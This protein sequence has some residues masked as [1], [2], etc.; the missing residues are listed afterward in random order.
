[1]NRE[2]LEAMIT[3]IVAEAMFNNFHAIKK[4]ILAEAGI[5][6]VDHIEF[7]SAEGPLCVMDYADEYT[8]Y[9][10][11]VVYCGERYTVIGRT[12]DKIR[13]KAAS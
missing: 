1:M 12:P 8:D 13:V 9:T 2:E 11:D 4:R 3:A 7:N 10:T 5:S 6:T